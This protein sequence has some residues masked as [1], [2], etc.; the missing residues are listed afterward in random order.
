[1]TV[2]NDLLSQDPG[3]IYDG[4]RKILYDKRTIQDVAVRTTLVINSASAKRY[5][6]FL[7]PGLLTGVRIS[8]NE[9]QE[10]LN[11]SELPAVKQATTPVPLFNQHRPLWIL[12][13]HC[14][15]DGPNGNLKLDNSTS[16]STEQ[17]KWLD[18]GEVVQSKFNHGISPVLTGAG[19]MLV[20]KICGAL[21]EMGYRCDVVHGVGKL[22]LNNIVTAFQAQAGDDND[23][24]SEVDLDSGISSDKN[25][26][27]AFRKVV[28]KMLQ[29]MLDPQVKGSKNIHFNSNEPVI[30]VNLSPDMS[31]DAFNQVLDQT[32]S[33]LQCRWNI[34][35]VRIYAGKFVDC[36]NA[37]FS[38]TLLN[39]VNTDIGGPSMIQLLDMHCEARGWHDYIRKEVWNGRDMVERQERSFQSQTKQNSP[40]QHSE[41]SISEMADKSH[42]LGAVKEPT[43]QESTTF[44]DAEDAS[45]FSLVASEKDRP[46]IDHPTWEHEDGDQSLMDL[47]RTQVLGLGLRESSKP[48]LD[49]TGEDEETGFSVV[50]TPSV[51]N[52]EVV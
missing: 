41:I 12:G 39:V 3:L 27:D 9:L 51:E 43:H 8:S 33:L 10:A 32:I 42:D 25:G 52:F 4:H 14:Q 11:D 19:I 26:S 2:L 34:W 38:I 47:I 18:V 28:S 16:A 48:H 44:R 49:Q 40:S 5:T 31:Q 36:L 21:S 50:E 23:A 17:P 30:L 7:G 24:I 22:V 1:M 46:E 6:G 15:Q 20:V 37:G 29:L 35:P 45:S 13:I